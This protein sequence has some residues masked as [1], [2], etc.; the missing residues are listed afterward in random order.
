MEKIDTWAHKL[1]FH[2]FIKKK[3]AFKKIKYVNF[4][5]YKKMNLS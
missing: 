3:T 1:N 5:K 4:I 2:T